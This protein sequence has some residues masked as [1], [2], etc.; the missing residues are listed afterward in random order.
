M[1]DGEVLTETSVTGIVNDIDESIIGD[2]NNT[3]NLVLS[4]DIN[5][6]MVVDK[7]PQVEVN[8]V[9]YLVKEAS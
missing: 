2:V 8:G 6:I 1:I 7:L 4:T 9:L 3:E 5:T